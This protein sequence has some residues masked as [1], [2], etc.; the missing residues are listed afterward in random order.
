MLVR[1]KNGQ[2]QVCVDFQDLNNVC[3][4]DDF[5]LPLTEIMVD[6]TTSH[7]ALSFMDGSLSYNQICMALKDEE[8]TT[9]RTHKGIYYYKVMSFWLKK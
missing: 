8:L 4:K 5:P 7:E 1:K 3:L 6:V 9:F 2:I